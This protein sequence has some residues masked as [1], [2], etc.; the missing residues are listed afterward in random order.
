MTIRIAPAINRRGSTSNVGSV[1]MAGAKY[2]P[3]ISL[4]P[5]VLAQIATTVFFLI[6]SICGVNFSGSTV[7][8]TACVCILIV[9]V[10]H[11][12]FDIRS[13]LATETTGLQQVTGLFLYIVTGT[14]MAAVWWYA[15]VFA[16]VLF[17]TTAISHFGEDWCKTDSPF[18][19]H[20]AALGLL[21]APTLLHGP[22]IVS[23]FTTIT[24]N[25]TSAALES[26]LTLVAPVAIAAALAATAILW[27]NQNREIAIAGFFALIGLIALPP[28]V[29][30]A[31]FF[32]L[33]H[34]PRHFA[35]AL[36]PD[37]RGTLN[38]WAIPIALTTLLAL[39]LA[40]II[41]WLAAF[42]SP[43]AAVVRASFISLSILT[44]PH[45]LL[46][47]I[48]CARNIERWLPRKEFNQRR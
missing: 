29:G 10:P 20:G 26:V 22:I 6:A 24:S 13:L 33:H 18:L 5:I 42:S 3:A 45:M 1:V 39:G 44:V 21:S 35:K 19:S 48:V 34:S 27:F 43:S 9:G 23:L 47:R 38:C 31:I 14:V 46:P 30:F 8:A 15:P 12:A 36:G 28:V 17:F 32:C 4:S 25:R 37:A 7:T 40:G 16:L 41:Y 2:A 11:G